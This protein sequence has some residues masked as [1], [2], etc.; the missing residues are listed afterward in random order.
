MPVSVSSYSIK[1]NNTVSEI[2]VNVISIPEDRLENILIKH[3]DRLKK[4]KDIVGSIALWL[5]ITIVLLTSNFNHVIFE[6]DTWK[7]IFIVL[8][9]ASLI[10]MVQTIR[11]CI[12]NRDSVENIMSDIKESSKQ[13]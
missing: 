3:V 6:P 9:A 5:T 8:F 7:G 12:S 10:Y 4:T 11:N 2:S 1:I 13:S